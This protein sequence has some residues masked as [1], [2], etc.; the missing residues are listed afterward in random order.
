MRKLLLLSN[1]EA[2]N[3]NSVALMY[4]INP[5][6]ISIKVK[7]LNENAISLSSSSDNNND[8]YKEN[9]FTYKRL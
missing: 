4:I 9:Y 6:S 2:N 1:N 3:S 7:Q 5:M 8:D